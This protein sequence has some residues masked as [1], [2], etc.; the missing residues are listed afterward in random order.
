MMATLLAQDFRATRRNL[1]IAAGLVVLVF[2]LGIAIAWLNIPIVSTIAIVLTIGAIASTIPLALAILCEYYWRTMYGR[3]G[4][5][6]M[7]VPVR[8]K[9]LFAAKVIYGIL[10]SLAAAAFMLALFYL[11]SG[12]VRLAGDHDFNAAFNDITAS[13]SEYGSTTVWV[14]GFLLVLQLVYVVVAGAAVMSI[15]ARARFNHLGCGAA[16]I[17]GVAVYLLTQILGLLGML[18]I[19]FGLKL[20]SAAQ[21][22]IVAEGMLNDFRA[23]IDGTAEKTDPVTL[24]LGIIPVVLIVGILLAYWGARSVEHHTSLR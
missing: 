5:F 9:T 10:V 7:S 24:G 14:I 20:Q 11:G 13:F 16:I 8:G 15:G 21:G 22:E 19:P 3:E 23:L 17:G 1:G 4:Y 12:I 2:G 18:F 6:T